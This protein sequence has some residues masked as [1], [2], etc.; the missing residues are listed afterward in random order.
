[1]TK[2]IP[3]QINAKTLTLTDLDETITL[4]PLDVTTYAETEG[5]KGL[6]TRHGTKEGDI[7]G[8]MVRNLTS[9]LIHILILLLIGKTRRTIGSIHFH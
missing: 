8:S 7:F 4:C 3:C 6:G 2:C 9:I 5:S 1:M